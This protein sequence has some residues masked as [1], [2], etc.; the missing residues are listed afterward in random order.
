MILLT[1]LRPGQPVEIEFQNG[2]KVR[3][4]FVALIREPN[5]ARFRRANEETLTI[6]SA[7]LNAGW[8]TITKI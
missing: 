3:G 1:S 5:G 7:E 4:E 2:R 6:L 8:V